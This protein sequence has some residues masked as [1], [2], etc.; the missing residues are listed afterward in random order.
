MCVGGWGWGVGVSNAKGGRVA[1]KIGEPSRTSE[2]KATPIGLLN[3]AFVPTP[4][5]KP[6]LPQL[7]LP[8]LVVT[9]PAGVTMRTQ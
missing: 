6:S 5:A 3:R 7:P 8:A 1:A 4:S 2:A 9:A